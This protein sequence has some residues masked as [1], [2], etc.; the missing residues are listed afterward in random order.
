MVL[1]LPNHQRYDFLELRILEVLEFCQNALVLNHTWGK[2]MVS[3]ISF[4]EN[5]AALFS[6]KW[7]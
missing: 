5:I 4:M 3:D 6:P 2:F 1:K 7:K